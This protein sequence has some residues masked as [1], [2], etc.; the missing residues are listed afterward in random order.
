ME[1]NLQNK[2][3]LVTGSTRG[4]GKAAAVML[5]KEGAKVVINYSK[6][7]DSA[8]ETEKI[9]K[10]QNADYKMFKADVSKTEEVS[11][12]IDMIKSEFGSLH[13]L[14][15]NA[16]IKDDKTIQKMDFESLDAVLKTN[17][18]GAFNCIKLSLP[19]LLNQESGSI[20]NI[21]SIIGMTGNFG[22]LNYTTSKSALIGLTK[23]L[24]KET[25]RKNVR[26]NAIAPGFIETDMLSGIPKEMKDDFLRHIPLGRF[27]KP[28]EVSN[29][30]CFLASDKSSYING[31][32]ILIDGGYY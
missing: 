22:Q 8:I 11:S 28:E 27:G 24:V 14:V 31:Q 26:V 21:T 6:D 3:A 16:G 23:S 30:I 12:M 5:A 19:I 29:L 7:K 25:G 17:L 13:I 1:F 20:I 18:Y 9:L 15:N 10:N 32:T 2:V 4:I